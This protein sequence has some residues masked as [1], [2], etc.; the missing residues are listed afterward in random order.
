MNSDITEIEATLAALKDGEERLRIA[1][2]AAELGVFEW[3]ILNDIAALQNDRMKEILGHNTHETSLKAE[4]ISSYIHPEDVGAFEAALTSTL[5]DQTAFRSTCRI[6][7]RVDGAPRWIEIAGNPVTDREGRVIKLVGVVSDITER[8]LAEEHARVLVGEVTHRSK[9]LLAVTQSIIR[10]TART[11]DVPSF[12]DGLLAR[13]QGLAASH[14]L[15][16]ANDWHSA[17]LETLIRAQLSH[18]SD[19]VDDRISLLGPPVRVRPAAAQ[20]IGMAFHELATNAT[21]YGS[22][23]CSGGSVK[24]HWRLDPRCAHSDDVGGVGAASVSSSTAGLRPVRDQTVVRAC[25]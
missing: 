21:K 17:D 5:L 19:L 16:I 13:L 25:A 14:D 23:S 24:I 12:V 7:R 11:K 20:A 2:L 8:Q 22:L 6:H 18:A 1:T 9:N 3:D 15:L 10:Q 4:F